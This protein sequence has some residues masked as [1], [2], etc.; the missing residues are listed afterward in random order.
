MQRYTPCKNVA[1]IH[2]LFTAWSQS[3]PT[4]VPKSSRSCPK[5]VP[6]LIQS[7]P[8]PNLPQSC[9]KVV[10]KF[11]IPKLPKNRPKVLSQLLQLVFQRCPCSPPQVF[12]TEWLYELLA[13]LAAVHNAPAVNSKLLKIKEAQTNLKWSILSCDFQKYWG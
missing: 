1:A 12:A 5:V 9:P 2:Y 3:C 4:V 13:E 10:V 8:K 6:I 7:C 11:N